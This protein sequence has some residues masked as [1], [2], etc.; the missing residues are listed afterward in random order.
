MGLER[1]QKNIKQTLPEAH[2]R[3]TTLPLLPEM[4]LY[5]LDPVNLQRMF[6]RQETRRIVRNAPYWSFCWASGQALGAYI[7]QRKTL[8]DGKKVLDFGSGSGVVAIAAA[9]AGAERVIACDSDGHALEAIRANAELNRVFIEAIRSLGELKGEVDLILVADLLY[10]SENF[11]LLDYFFAYTDQI[12]LADSR[13]KHFQH[14]RYHQVD[15][16]TAQTI[17]DLKEGE[18]FNRVQIYRGAWPEN[19]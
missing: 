8:I 4:R 13:I 12:L 17:P 3:E 7:S 14:P 19:C 1:L 5:L 18:E 15:H 2:L 16:I 11:P 6:S 9:R 10:D